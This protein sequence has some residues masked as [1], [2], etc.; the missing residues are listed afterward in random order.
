MPVNPMNIFRSFM[1]SPGA[2]KATMMGGAVG[3]GATVPDAIEGYVEKHDA[4]VYQEGAT[5]GYQQGVETGYQQGMQQGAEMGAQQA[6][7][8]MLEAMQQGLGDGMGAGLDYGG[9]QDP[10]GGAGMYHAA[11]AVRAADLIG[12]VG[13]TGRLPSPETMGRATR[14]WRKGDQTSRQ[15]VR[16]WN[17]VDRPGEP[18]VKVPSRSPAQ[19]AEQSDW[20]T[21]LHGLEA[22]RRHPRHLQQT[23]AATKNTLDTRAAARGKLND[24]EGGHAV[25][26]AAPPAA[27]GFSEGVAAKPA[28]P[29]KPL[30]AGKIKVGSVL[31][32]VPAAFADAL[33]LTPER[34]KVASVRLAPEFEVMVKV[35]AGQRAGFVDPVLANAAAGF[36]EKLAGPGFVAMPSAGRMARAGLIGLGV[37]GAG[38]AA[39]LA[40]QVPGQFR[41]VGSNFDDLAHLVTEKDGVNPYSP[42]REAADSAS[43][44]LV[45]GVGRGLGIDWVDTPDAAEVFREAQALRLA[46]DKARLLLSPL[47]RI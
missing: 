26:A 34:T 45:S 1:K 27:P 47:T 41:G 44:G 8:Q 10:Y 6:A 42:Y 18:P 13:K 25:F 35:A 31:R 4:G 23:M 12:A 43:E 21:A 29:V 2:R 40:S 32:E 19:R 9:E 37:G 20:E 17:K 7:Q 11:S 22:G 38:S 14:R 46:E 5:T 24:L 15:Q 16:D 30:P 3:A 39:L 36:A 33:G 28:K